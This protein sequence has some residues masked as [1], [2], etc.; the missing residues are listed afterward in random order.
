[1]LA[2]S[3]PVTQRGAGTRLRAGA[4]IGG[5]KGAFSGNA[6]AAAKGNGPAVCHWGPA[7]AHH[8]GANSSLA[9][10]A[11]WLSPSVFVTARCWGE[12]Q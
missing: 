9:S 2:A 6:A 3:R 7:A 4:A 5:L 11:G 10:K 8:R 1:M 12:R